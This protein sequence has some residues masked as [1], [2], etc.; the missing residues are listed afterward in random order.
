MRNPHDLFPKVK[1][2]DKSFE[3]HQRINLFIDL[4]LEL[5]IASKGVP[6]DITRF[7]ILVKELGFEM[8]DID[9]IVKTG[10][11]QLVILYKYPI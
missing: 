5:H 8:E 4:F 2:R 7:Q 3:Q 6:C 9:K 1:S 10:I 11:H